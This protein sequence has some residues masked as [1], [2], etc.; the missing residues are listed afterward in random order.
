MSML[1]DMLADV[2]AP[3][4]RSQNFSVASL[5]YNRELGILTSYAHIVAAISA[6]LCLCRL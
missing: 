6:T 1:G 4:A 3:F 5:G 2:P